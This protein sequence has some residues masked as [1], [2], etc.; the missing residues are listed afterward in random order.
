VLAQVAL[1]IARHR[2]G[3]RREAAEEEFVQKDRVRRRHLL[4]PERT[5][6]S[7]AA[8]AAIGLLERSFCRAERVDRVH[9]CVVVGGELC[10]CEKAWQLRMG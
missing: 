7:E 6:G 10:L 2:N 3:V 8:G 4:L 1:D 5:V 9:I